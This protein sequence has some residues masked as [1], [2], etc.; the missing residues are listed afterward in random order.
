MSEQPPARGWPVLSGRVPALAEG[1]TRRTESGQELSDALPPGVTVVLGPYGGPR[2]SARCRGGTG[3]TQLAVAFA[4]GMWARGQLDLLVWLDAGSRDRLV[5]GYARTV[6]DVRLAAPTG[7]PEAAAAQFLTWLGETSRRWL[8]VLDGLAEPADAEGLWPQGPN[9]NVLVTTQLPKPRPASTPSGRERRETTSARQELP[10]AVS[11]FSQR[12][13]V[14]YVSDRLNDD[15]FHAAGAI[16]LVATLDCLPVGLDLAVAY[17]LDTGQDCRRYRL[18]YDQYKRDWA[19]G[20]G[21]DLL[22]PSWMLAVDRA[23]QFV[24]T[25]LPWPSLQLASVLGPSIPGAVLTNTAACSYVTGQEVITPADQ[26]SLRTAFGNLQRVGLVTIEPEDE[27]RTVCMPAALQASIRQVMGPAEVRLAVQAAGDAVYEAWPDNAGA[28]MEQALRDCATSLRRCDDLALW[29]PG[30]HP[31]LLRAG[32]S[33]DDAHMVETALGYWRDIAGRSVQQHGI[34]SQV[35]LLLREELASAAT[36]AGHND[37]AISL[38]SDLVGDMEKVA[39]PTSAQAILARARLVAA[40]RKAGRLNDAIS[41]GTV[42]ATDS[43]ALLGAAH[44]QTRHSLNELGGAY[45]DAGQYREAIDVLQ[46]SLALHAETIGVMHPDTVSARH[47]L[48]ETYRRA[49]RGAAAIKI[50]QDALTQVENR[51]GPTHRD[52]ITAREGLAIAYYQAGQLTEAAGNFERAVAQ[53]RRV[54]NASPASSITARTNLA[55]TYCVG[56]RQRDAIPLYEGVLE[57]L[58]RTRGPGHPDTFR[59][60]WN[61]AAA[62]HKARRLDEA[63]ELGEATLADS[64]RILGFGHRET[65]TT[66]A[67]LAHAYHANGRLKRASAHFDRAIRDCERAVGPD[68]PLTAAVHD[69]RNRYLA[70]RQGIAPIV[71]PPQALSPRPGYAQRSAPVPTA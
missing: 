55:A 36:A 13:A 21:G 68:D 17:L 33:L 7:K 30:C 3:K 63:V 19:D 53:W 43:D 40:F 44:A 59:A 56:G 16:D 64:E 31:L 58:Q 39:G 26:A 4:R 24:P 66:R 61:L 41:L 22:A 28:D 5:A 52:A 32:R 27:I 47:E 70:G 67:N 2:P 6:T 71:A 51:V 18:A 57:D 38:R 50:Y 46:S 1:Y 11:P 48:A 62:Y 20:M 10:I 60:R 23:R 29:D 8:V 25:D 9:G 15:P 12:E 35:T 49:G 14:Q 69:L 65:L 34:R 37:E 54:P 42:T 45:R